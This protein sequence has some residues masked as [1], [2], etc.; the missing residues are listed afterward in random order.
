[1][2]DPAHLRFGVVA[3]DGR[4]ESVESRQLVRGE[5]DRVGGDVFLEA[6]DALGSRNGHD[7][8]TLRQQPGQCDLSRSRADVGGDLTYFVCA[9]EIVLE[10]L[11]EEAWVGLAVV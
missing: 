6:G 8:G 10:V 3:P 9:P 1:P 7:V 4:G 11:V 2:V 5:L